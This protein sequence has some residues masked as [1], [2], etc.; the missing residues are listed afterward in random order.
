MHRP[1]DV[2]K[3]SIRTFFV[4]SPLRKGESNVLR[5]IPSGS[6]KGAAKTVQA[7]WDAPKVRFKAVD[8]DRLTP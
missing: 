5:A 7:V 6:S 3:G 8:S 1:L 4:T 2:T